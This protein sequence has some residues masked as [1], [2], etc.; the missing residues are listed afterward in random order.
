MGARP[1]YAPEIMFREIAPLR[2]VNY[3]R[4]DIPSVE[5]PFYRIP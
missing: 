4:R 5:S 2:D 1:I 3:V